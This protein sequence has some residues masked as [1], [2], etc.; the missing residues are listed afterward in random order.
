M[1]CTTVSGSSLFEKEEGVFMPE[2][3]PEVIA[4]EQHIEVQQV[5][6]VVKLFEEGATVPFIARYRKEATGALDEVQI[7]AIRD[8]L[9]KLIELNKR[10]E[11][12]LKSMREHE[13]L[14]PELEEEIGKADTLSHLEDLY[15]PFRPKRRTRAIIAKEK[16]LE[17][18]AHKIYDEDH[19]DLNAEAEKAVNPEKGV[20]TVEYALQGARDIVAE[21]MSED[22]DVRADLRHL[23]E[24]EA[25][26]TATVNKAKER[27]R[28]AFKYKDYF[29]WTEKAHSAP[30]HRIL[31]AMRG[32]EEGYLSMHIRPDDEA[33]IEM[34]ERGFTAGRDDDT[35]QLKL[36]IRDAYKRLIAPSLENEFRK[37]IKQRADEAAVQV[38]AQNLK[39]LM[40]A[41][42]LGQKPVLA[43]DPGL[44]TGCKV[45]CLTAQGDLVHSETIFPLPPR[46]RRQDASDA[47][48]K[49]VEKYKIEAIAVGNGTGGRE[50]F[51]FVRSLGMK[52]P[53]VMVNESGA[54]VYSASKAAREEFPDYDVTVRGAISIGRRLMDPLAELVKIDPKAIG[55]G[56]YQHDVDQKLL[57]RSL[58]DVVV[59]AVNSVGVEVNTASP[60]LMQYVSGLGGRLAT[61]IA[62][63]REANGPFK[64]KDDLKSVEGMGDKTYELA[65]GFLRIQD[66]E[67]PLDASA[68]HPERYELVNK[69]AGDI[70]VDVRALMDDSSLRDQLDLNGYAEGDVGLP[71]L[72]DIVAELAKPGRDPRAEFEAIAFAEGVTEI[73]QLTPGMELPG[74]VTN[75]T[76][77]GAFVDIG[78]HQDGLVHISELSDEFIQNPA[79]IVKVHQ[80]VKVKVL[81][82]DAD[83]KR[84]ALTMKSGAPS[85]RSAGGDRR[86]P[87]RDD[88]RDNRGGGPRG[89]NSR[90]NR[91]GG[92]RGGRSNNSSGDGYN[93]F[94][95]LLS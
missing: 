4:R 87:R 51:S 3:Y 7:I 67:N 46:N 94:A 38:F 56:Q 25:I 40:L 72:K 57:K 95:D 66:A 44:R 41:A 65:A 80:Q 63:Y 36:S 70:G 55:V 58:D 16:G 34:L 84:I 29:D 22:P 52:I 26:I 45:V 48:K 68:V 13:Q 50:A 43:I 82:V 93:P 2:S 15:L 71:T 85:Q 21:W 61:A 83:R 47:L 9:E 89:G 53:L 5:Q 11:A 1:H 62:K 33:T 60:H 24:D 31:A 54:S 64:T 8:R 42:P 27:E 32:A 28:E 23:F 37:T 78:V 49:M 59:S 6:A 14:T 73:S 88:N 92:Q 35:E 39:D 20:D 90:D 74:I 30:S 81:E 76:N 12:I 86:P 77:F 18:L 19:I 17:D 75:V 79:D 10:R 69:M 91:G